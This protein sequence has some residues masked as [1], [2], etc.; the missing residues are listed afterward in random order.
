MLFTRL[1]NMFE[2]RYG[3]TIRRFTPQQL[4]GHPYVLQMGSVRKRDYDD[5]WV[6][7]LA[8]HSHR[9][10]DVGANIGQAALLMIA[11]GDIEHMVLFEANPVALGIAAEN[12]IRNFLSAK[13][14]FIPGFVSD[15]MDAVIEFHTLGSGAAGSMFKS[16]SVSASK[17]K[18]SIQIPTVTLDYVVK[19][20]GIVPDL[21]KIDVEGAETQVLRG[22]TQTA[23]QHQMK[24]IVEMHSN[25]ELSMKQ[26]AQAVLDWCREVG[27]SAW[28]LLEHKKLTST[29]PIEK[30][31][32]C[33]LLLLPEAVEYPDYLLPLHQGDSIEKALI[34]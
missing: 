24:L 22:F 13:V 7:A 29:E 33:H 4:L 3:L 20:T 18:S 21:V 19:T 16:H 2:K 11:A 31:G 32:R 8:S 10:F 15:R 28:Y 30:R 34:P 23:S 17:L 1:A 9:I 14:R 5:A 27:Y 6:V 26:N 25:P 12:L